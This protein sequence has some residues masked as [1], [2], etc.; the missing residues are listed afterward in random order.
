ML[1]IVLVHRAARIRGPVVPPTPWTDHVVTSPNDRVVTLRRWWL[2]SLSGGLIGGGLVGAIAGGAAWYAGL[3]G[4]A[5]F[6]AAALVGTAY[7]GGLA[8]AWLAGQSSVSTGR[9]WARPAAALR[10]MRVDDLRAQAARS[11]TLG[12]S[13][14]SGDLRAARFELVAPVTRLRRARLRHHGPTAT[15][16][17]RDL[18]GIRRAPA[19]V[20]VGGAA[21]GIA[22]AALG[23]AVAAPGAPVVA[24]LLAGLL[25][26]LGASAFGE[27]MRQQADNLTAPAMLG[28][29]RRRESVAHAVPV[30]VGALLVG[31]GPLVAVAVL[32]SDAWAT[33]VAAALLLTVLLV[34]SVA[35]AAFRG[36]MPRSPFAGSGVPSTL[37]GW[38][39]FPSLLA[40]TAA[41]AL[42]QGLVGAPPSDPWVAALPGLSFAV[43]LLVLSDVLA[44]RMAKAHRDA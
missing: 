3:G 27:G 10:G 5:A 37:I 35:T 36:P 8:V 13:I 21:L 28:I 22:G 20:V 31:G 4:V 16:V 43:A 2:V 11:A 7:G 42:R 38:Y 12:G 33:G 34:G 41:L 24:A 44:E 30:A 9:I 39:A 6:S 32:T 19:G 14:L 1:G 40:A 23:W 17:A 26:H 15:V 29:S 18:L 25:A